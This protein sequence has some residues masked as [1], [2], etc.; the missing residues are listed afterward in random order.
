MMEDPAPNS[1]HHNPLSD[2][3]RVAG[4]LVHDLANDMQVLQGWAALARMEAE[5][6]RIPIEELERVTHLAEGLGRMLQDVLA[7]VSDQAL[8]PE[9]AF[10]P[11]ALTERTLSERLKDIAIPDVRLRARLAD[12][13]Q[14]AGRAS[15]WVRIVGNLLR[16]AG[17]HARSR[18]LVRLELDSAGQA[19]DAVVLRVEDDGPGISHE[20][21]AAVFE[22]LWRGSEGGAGLGLSS[23][24]W[25]AGRLGGSV[26]Y[27]A[28]SELGGAAFEVRVPVSRPMVV[29]AQTQRRAQPGLQGFRL[30]LID[31]DAAI[32][33][34]VSRLLRRSGADA[35]DLDPD[36]LPEDRLVEEVASAAPDV[37]LMDLNLR[38]R[39][40][41]TLW[42]RLRERFPAVADRVVFIS[43]AAP[44]DQ[45]W[46]DA[47]RTGRPVLTKPF[48]I[49]QLI[50]LL[51]TLGKAR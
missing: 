6:G 28:D 49:Q 25:T 12:D 45:A 18:I 9:V 21:Q 42:H 37:I 17:R 19:G 44:G 15:F 50:Q 30:I 47:R 8:S 29:R 11:K 20:L 34:A 38:G 23:V 48:D 24:V 4:E 3:G 5:R 35:R 36:S 40:G 26:S 31:D 32:R 27:A 2:F 14:V 1:T 22:P 51:T 13:V 7:T 43:G 10:H 16:N 33:H 41:V 46:D 39:A